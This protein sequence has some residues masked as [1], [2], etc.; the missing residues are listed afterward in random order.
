MKKIILGF[1]YF[2]IFIKIGHSQ[3]LCEKTWDAYYNGTFGIGYTKHTKNTKLF[4]DEHSIVNL[5]FD[6]DDIDVYTSSC[7]EQ[8]QKAFDGEYKLTF[9]IKSKGESASFS[10]TAYVP[11]IMVE[12]RK[13][14]NAMNKKTGQIDYTLYQ[15]ASIVKLYFKDAWVINKKNIDIEVKVEDITAFLVSTFNKGYRK[16]DNEKFTPYTFV[17]KPNISCPQNITGIASNPSDNVWH[18]VLTNSGPGIGIDYKYELTPDMKIGG[19]SDFKNSLIIED[20]NKRSSVGFFTISDLKL[21]FKSRYN[22]N[23]ADTALELIFGSS[24]G[25]PSTFTV[26]SNG[27][28]TDT[29]SGFE[30][31]SLP[32]SKLSGITYLE[33]AFRYIDFNKFGLSFEQTYSCGGNK[34]GNIK[35]LSKRINN[36]VIDNNNELSYDVQIKKNH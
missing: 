4:A 12:A 35:K 15:N 1:L 33:E 24:I 6:F 31:D 11:T 36:A 26:D 21:S 29:H 8:T 23:D 2:C 14:L 9:T 19:I 18:N 10:P 16:D 34:I 27:Q 25:T 7:N 28:F 22:I 3:S 5:T 30:I 13:F 32:K 20:F 17:Y